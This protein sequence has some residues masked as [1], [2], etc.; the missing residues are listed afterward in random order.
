MTSVHPCVTRV[1]PKIDLPKAGSNPHGS[2]LSLVPLSS[3]II[4]FLLNQIC[5]RRHHP[6]PRRCCRRIHPQRRQ[7][8]DLTVLSRT[9]WRV[10]TLNEYNG[11]RVRRELSDMKKRWSL[12]SRR[13]A[14][15]FGTSN[16]RGIGG[17][18]LCR[19]GQMPRASATRPASPTHLFRSRSKTGF[20]PMHAGNPMCI[21]TL[22]HRS[23]AT[24]GS[25]YWPILLALPGWTDTH[26]LLTPPPRDLLVDIESLTLDLHLSPKCL[27]NPRSRN[28]ALPLMNLT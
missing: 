2:G 28:P 19:T 1:N 20:V 10:R 24:G 4:P 13:W 27:R 8:K 18:P 5:R 16:G 25:T 22:L 11:Q 26:L 12:R 6:H 14:G 15:P 7:T 21:T 17:W 9:A 23:L 3:Q